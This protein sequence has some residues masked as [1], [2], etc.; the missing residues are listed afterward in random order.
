MALTWVPGPGPAWRSWRHSPS[1]SS[2]LSGS[3]RVGLASHTRAC[4]QP[5]N[6]S[7]RGWRAARSIPRRRRNGSEASSIAAGR[8]ASRP[9]RPRRPRGGAGGGSHD[10]RRS[11][12][13]RRG[14]A[15][16][17]ASRSCS[18]PHAALRLVDETEQCDVR[19]EGPGDGETADGHGQDG[20]A[21]VSAHRPQPTPRPPLRPGSRRRPATC[22]W[23]V[24]HE[25]GDQVPVASRGSAP[26]NPR[27][28]ARS[29]RAARPRPC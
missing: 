6:S 9:G 18:L 29:R 2:R 28:R 8:P 26:R 23:P 1:P 12:R 11:R 13:L 20:G 22:S 4:Q 21:H 16:G 27:P 15:G 24:G 10:E 14:A 5:A 3:L 25:R 7:M 17:R 19:G